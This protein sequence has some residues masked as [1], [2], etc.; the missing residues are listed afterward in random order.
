[1]L[2]KDIMTKEVIRVK[3]DS[4]VE[5]VIKLVLEHNISGL[6][7]VDDEN[8]VIGIITEGDLIYRSK[9]LHI[10]TYFTL[11]DSYIFLENPQN[12]EAQLKKMV[13]YKVKDVMTSKV[14]MVDL[15]ETIEEIATL[16]SEKNINRVPVVKEG[17]L[18]GIVSRRDII[19]AYA[20]K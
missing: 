4:T 18:M 15:E 19:K 9:K 14:I 3:K 16:M 6:P 11:L 5:E 12:L 7:V 2:A 20:N 10:P 1:M 8:N 13:G 17:K